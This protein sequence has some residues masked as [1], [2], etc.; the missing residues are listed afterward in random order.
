[1]FLFKQIPL[2]PSNQLLSRLFIRTLASR[3]YKSWSK[4]EKQQLVTHIQE[5]YLAIGCRVDWNKVGSVFGTSAKACENAYHRIFR[6]E[7]DKRNYEVQLKQASVKLEEDTTRQLSKTILNQLEMLGAID[8]DS[9]AKK[10]NVPAL[11]V[12]QWV[13]DNGSLCRQVPITLRA[14][15][16]W[17]QQSLDRLQSFVDK[18]FDSTIDWTVVSLY[19]GIKELDCAS[20]YSQ[21]KSANSGIHVYNKWTSEEDKRLKAAVAKYP[22]GTK[23]SWVEAAKEVG[24][25]RNN[26]NCKNHTAAIRRKEAKQIAVWTEVELDTVES[27]LS[28][29]AKGERIWDKLCQH[30]PGKSKD[31]IQVKAAIIRDESSVKGL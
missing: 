25:G 26:V 1:M 7:K 11:Q 3:S 30:I 16:K 12:L 14:P 22:P 6:S 4:E 9:I 28:N 23:V 17:S 29:A 31:Q 27:V 2:L 24:T 5:G 18:H 20:A 10:M 8:W 13:K 15:M 19:M 21:V